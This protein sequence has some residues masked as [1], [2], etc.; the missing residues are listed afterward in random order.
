L[1]AA[2]GLKMKVRL[3]FGLGSRGRSEIAELR[4]E[5]RGEWEKRKRK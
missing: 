1:D 2:H 3:S 4:D 5:M